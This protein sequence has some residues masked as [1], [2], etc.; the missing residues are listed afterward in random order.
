MKPVRLILAPLVALFIAGSSSADANDTSAPVAPSTHHVFEIPQSIGNGE[1]REVSVL[2]DARHL[3]LAT[4]VLRDGSIL[5]S[6][7]AEVPATI[8]VLAGEGVIHVG[9]EAVPL[10]RGTL[11]ALAANEE[12]DVAPRPGGDM[13][14]LV[15]YLR[16]AGGEPNRSD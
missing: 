11:V 14:L 4:V 10:S 12:H 16:A 5:P 8:L 13:V 9:N 2:L 3:K 15:H 7:R 1:G 6:H